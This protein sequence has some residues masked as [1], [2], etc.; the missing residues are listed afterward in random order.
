VSNT[1][2]RHVGVPP[3]STAEGTRL[4]VLDSGYSEVDL[5]HF[6]GSAGKASTDNRSPVAT[7]T[8]APVW[9]V[10]IVHPQGTILFDAGLHPDTNKGRLSAGTLRFFPWVAGPEQNV[11]SRLVELGIAPMQV[12][13]VVASHL[14]FDH[15]GCLA[16]FTTAS[17][18]AHHDEVSEVMR[19]Y[20]V[21]PRSL[22]YLGYGLK[23][24]QDWLAAK[25]KWQLVARAEPD[26]EIFPGIRVINFGSGHTF[27]MLGLLVNLPKTGPILL[28][29]D[30]CCR[31]EN[32]GPQPQP[33]GHC[34]DSL[35]NECGLA[36]I[37]QLALEYS[38]QVWFGHDPKQFEGLRKS[39]K[40]F[41]A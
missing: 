8:R 6:I 24:I 3:L 18:L 9:A 5:S 22:S 41:Y 20:L 28:V 34:Y 25:L 10:L 33:P 27:G 30:A 40:E 14:H 35:G 19:R 13:Y 7:W 21:D 17:I 23:D 39:P 12:N 1:A 4:Y 31:Q 29:S 38:A 26:L 2:L 11:L 37:R 36:R 16:A 32:L 15:A